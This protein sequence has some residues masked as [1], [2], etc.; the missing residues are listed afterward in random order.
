MYKDIDGTLGTGQIVPRQSERDRTQKRDSRT[1]PLIPFSKEP[2]SFPP[3]IYPK[4]I[5]KNE[6]KT[7]KNLS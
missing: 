2:P 6:K 5:N 1:V 4:I 7:C 3:T